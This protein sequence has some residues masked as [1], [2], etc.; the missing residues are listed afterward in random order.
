MRIQ[1]QTELGQLTHQ[2]RVD[3]GLTQFELA[4]RLGVTRQWVARFEKGIG[5]PSL[6]KALLVLHELD[7]TIDIR[8][9]TADGI[10][11][12][13][14]RLPNSSA[15]KAA[16]QAALARLAASV[17]DTTSPS[18]F[19]HTAPGRADASA[20]P[21]AATFKL[22]RVEKNLRLTRGAEEDDA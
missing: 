16:S 8:P 18:N 6:T 11:T 22:D 3:I 13:E 14:F 15:I 21:K 9:K 1:Q 5:E 19:A 10:A 12:V 4:E 2:R 20:L 17:G 7:L